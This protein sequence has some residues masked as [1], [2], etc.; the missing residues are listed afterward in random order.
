MQLNK[1]IFSLGLGV[2][3]T[4][5]GGSDDGEDSGSTQPPPTISSRV[6]SGT[7]QQLTGERMQ[8]NHQ[9]IELV[10]AKVQ[11]ADDMWADPLQ[12]GM[13][14]E[15][16]VTADKAD[17]VTL[18][19]LLTGQLEIDDTRSEN[20]IWSVNG[21]LLDKVE[22]GQNAGDWVMVFGEYDAQGRV[23]TS[24][25]TVLISKPMWFEIE[26][27]IVG[28]DSTTETFLMGQFK[29]SYAGAHI[30]DGPLQEG[31]W[32]EVFGL[33]QGEQLKAGKVDID[34]RDS[35]PDQ[36]EIEGR[37]QYFEQS[38]GLL[39]LDRQRQVWVTGT[40]RFEN[41]S[42]ANLQV[43]VEVEVEI[44]LGSQGM[45]AA[46]IEFDDGHTPSPP[47]PNQQFKLSG[48]ADWDGGVLTING[49]RFELD[50]LTRLGDGLTK[51]NLD[52]RW[53]ELDGIVSAGLNLVREIEPDEK[54]DSLEL[55]GLVSLGQLWGY[56]ASD[57]SLENYDGR[58]MDL[59]CHFDGNM[60]SNCRMDD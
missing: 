54:D 52:G 35:L 40:T 56:R 11:Y 59:D 47:I 20:G 31:R 42:Q 23:I 6:V 16:V 26:N 43:G 48:L 30:E 55:R 7:I 38:T 51:D 17:K 28:L 1:V 41:G 12:I 24:E 21:V 14:V 36:S 37:I 34:D 13:D 8:V 15:V 45:I 32:A 29:V 25:V 3:L 60:I 53:V 27:R 4:A 10:G 58:W 50:E 18:N 19:P 46:E 2:I 49:I 44:R 22:V 9:W 5:C 57:N 33:L 39:E